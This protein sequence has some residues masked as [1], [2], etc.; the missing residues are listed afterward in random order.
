MR[1]ILDVFMWRLFDSEMSPCSVSLICKHIQ[2]QQFSWRLGWKK[3]PTAMLKPRGVYT[4]GK[5][6]KSK[7]AGRA[8]VAC[9]PAC[10][11]PGDANV[12]PDCHVSSPRARWDSLHVGPLDITVS[13]V[14]WPLTP[15]HF[16]LGVNDVFTPVH[17]KQH[18]PRV[19]TLTEE[20]CLCLSNSEKYKQI[21]FFFY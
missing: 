21:C 3:N 19:H 10:V 8:T 16:K 12:T 14:N 15:G 18:T 5:C 9:L 13:S 17:D 7:G 6:V 20:M 4:V 11:T 1:L 2:C